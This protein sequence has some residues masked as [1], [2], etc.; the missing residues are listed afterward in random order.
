ML[1]LDLRKRYFFLLEV[2]K[3][4][5][6]FTISCDL[7]GEMHWKDGQHYTGEFKHGVQHG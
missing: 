3:I 5:F 2:F 4:K 7:S 6:Y 1:H